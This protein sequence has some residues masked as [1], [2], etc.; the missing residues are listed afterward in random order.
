M[1]RVCKA[2]R[3][4]ALLCGVLLPVAVAFA[5]APSSP[6]SCSASGQAS[7]EA[8]RAATATGSDASVSLEQRNA[9]VGWSECKYAV[10][11]P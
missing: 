8:V 2:A 4:F 1:R 7:G 3:G 10:M 5:G 6:Q 11:S 9:L